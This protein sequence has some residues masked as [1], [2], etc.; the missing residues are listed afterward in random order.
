[1]RPEYSPGCWVEVMRV[2]ASEWTVQ[3]ERND[4][5]IKDEI[6]NK[7]CSPTECERIKGER[8]VFDPGPIRE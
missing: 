1:M 4:H 5:I 2:W 6:I 8:N 3:I 7:I